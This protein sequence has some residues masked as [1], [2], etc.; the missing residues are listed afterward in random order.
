MAFNA[1]AA[2]RPLKSGEEQSLLTTPP[3]RT[4]RASFPAHGSSHTK[5][6]Y[7]SQIRN[8]YVGHELPHGKLDAREPNCRA[9]HPH[10]T[11]GVRRDGHAILCRA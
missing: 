5:A 7:I 3:L 4:V 9:N 11:D 6:N 10:Q 8:H 2:F 1:G